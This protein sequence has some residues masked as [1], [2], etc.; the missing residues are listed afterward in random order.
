M[1]RRWLNIRKGLLRSILP[2]LRLLPHRSAARIVAGIGRLEYSL[3]P[4]LR[5]RYDE[6]VGRVGHYLGCRWDVA[7]VG[8]ELA[9]NQIRWRTRDLLLDGR[10]DRRVADLFRVV[11][12]ECIDA[13]LAERRGVILL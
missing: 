10:P 8:R 13:A 9:G 1:R 7:A 6:A 3:V 5:V 2:A 4:R 12:R 11:G